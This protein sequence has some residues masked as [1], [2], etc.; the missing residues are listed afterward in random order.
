VKAKIFGEPT[1]SCGFDKLKE[2]GDSL[3][4]VKSVI[5]NYVLN[6]LTVVIWTLKIIIY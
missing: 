2:I 5:Q 1:F 6:V 4:D 3:E